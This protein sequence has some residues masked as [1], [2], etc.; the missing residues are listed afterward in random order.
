MGQSNALIVVDHTNATRDFKNFLLRNF[1]PRIVWRH[2]VVPKKRPIWHYLETLNGPSLIRTPRPQNG[3]PDRTAALKE[4]LLRQS[5][6]D[7]LWGRTL[8]ATDK[9]SLSVQNEAP[10]HSGFPNSSIPCIFDSCVSQL[11]G[12]SG[13]FTWGNI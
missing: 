4:S 2:T 8:A 3:K 13:W 10:N 6:S 9:E 1:E 7:N 12:N 11:S 5:F